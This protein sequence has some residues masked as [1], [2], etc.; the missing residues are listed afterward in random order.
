[1][2]KYILNYANVLFLAA[3]A[4]ALFFTPTRQIESPAAY[5]VVLCL[6][7][8][9]YL[10]AYIRTGKKSARDIAGIVFAILIIWDIC[11]RRGM[12][13]TVLIPPA[14]NVFNVFIT[15]RSLMLEG[16][17]SSMKLL[18]FGVGAALILGVGLGLV[19]GWIPRVRETVLPIANV[20][21][22]IPPLVYTPYVVAAMPT[23]K[24]AS[25]FV[26]FMAVFW[27]TFQNMVTRVGS[28]DRK[29][30]QSAQVMNVSTPAM[31]FRVILP[32]CKPGIL[33]SLNASMR[34]ALLCLTGAE[35][36]GA[37]S[38]LGYFVKKF[39]DFA[40]Y[41]KVLAGIILMGVV[42]TLLSMLLKFIQKKTV[43]WN[44]T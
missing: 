19:V 7:Q 3:V 27:P 6:T 17:W 30:I 31:I 40:N 24:A 28:I 11:A 29:I 20:I 5:I 22:P 10:T 42:V 23:F 34:A 18:F 38:G 41:T 25:V 9:L 14:E 13:N 2:R 33:T 37:T 32:Y 36:L 39:S 21:S 12:G 26:I 16:V 4:V 15:E 44:Y 8:A 1:M 43:K 35:L